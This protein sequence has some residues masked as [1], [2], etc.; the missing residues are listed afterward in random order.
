MY[1]Q[2]ELVSSNN[3]TF[4]FWLKEDLQHNP[5]LRVGHGVKLLEVEP[6]LRVNRVF[7][8]LKNLSDLPVKHRLGTIVEIN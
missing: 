3:Q 7:I 1:T 8:S 6:Y 5:K 2:V 4:T